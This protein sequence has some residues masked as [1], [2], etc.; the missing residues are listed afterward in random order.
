MGLMHFFSKFTK[1]VPPPHYEPGTF[2]SPTESTAFNALSKMFDAKTNVLAKVCLAELVATPRD[3]Q[4]LAHW[5]RVQR[6]TVDFLV[7]SAPCVK[8]VLAIKLET[9]VDSKKRR[10]N[11]PDILE[12]VLE[13]IGLPL[14]R[15]RAQDQYDAED[16]VKKINLALKG[17]RNAGPV[18]SQRNSHAS[19][20]MTTV[21]NSKLNHVTTSISN[22]W[23]Q[24][25]VRCRRHIWA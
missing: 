18:A 20:A 22:I 13:D 23:T 25:K 16:L 7:C 9:E 21:G 4:Y 24:T 3:R 11:G 5:R 12:E 15:L 2:L 17:N 6:R 19:P 8:P 10:A 1:A 14:L